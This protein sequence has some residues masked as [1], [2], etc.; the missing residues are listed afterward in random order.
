MDISMAAFV[1]WVMLVC[2][3]TVCVASGA[4]R[5]SAADTPASYGRADIDPENDA[6]VAPPEAVP[7]CE[8]RLQAAGVRFRPLPL[9]LHQKRGGHYTCGTEQA[10]VYLGG[11]ERIRYSPGPPTVG[12]G[13]ALALLAFERLLQEEATRTLGK[14]VARIE[15]GGS[16]SCRK[17]TRFR[18][19]V[20]EHSYANAIDIRGLWLEDGRKVSVLRDFGA[21]DREPNSPKSRL[22]RNAA[23]RAFDEG[24]FSVVLTP[25]WDKLHRDHLHLDLA[26]YRV[27]G[28]R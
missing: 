20:S 15:Q 5:S 1:R 26:R 24:V 4:A 3:V 14:R 11:P 2:V 16:Y 21:L 19:M 23:R 17:M 9:P 12:C 13:M 18:N 25:F 8:A 27:D 28:T 7:D 22:L 10:V 6:V